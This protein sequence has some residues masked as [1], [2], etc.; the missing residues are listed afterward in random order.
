MVDMETVGTAKARIADLAGAVVEL[1]NSRPHANPVLPDKL[2]DPQAAKRILAP[3]GP[4]AAAGPSSEQLALVRALRTD[5][6]DVIDTPDAEEEARGWDTLTAHSASAEFRQTFSADGAR[7]RQV[8]G[9]PLVGGLVTSVA[10]LVREGAW[11]RFRV[12][13]NGNCRAVFYDT[14]RSRSQRWHSYEL[15]GNRANVAAY[16]TRKRT[17]SDLGGG[18]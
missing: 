4:S 1:L 2:D 18:A 8:A 13:G 17:A 12:C 10:E 11:T 7:L 15:C 9:D 6:M 16:R 3:F 14:T 5:L